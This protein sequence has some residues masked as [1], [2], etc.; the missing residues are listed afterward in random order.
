MMKRLL[1]LLMTV[2]AVGC[3][4]APWQGQNAEYT[5]A[6]GVVNVRSA[7]AGGIARQVKVEAR[8]RYLISFEA[9]GEGRIQMAVFG[10]PATAFTPALKL[11]PEQWEKQELSYF[12]SANQ[13]SLK[14]YSVGSAAGTFSIRNFTVTPQAKPELADR[15]ITRLDF[16]AGDYPGNGKLVKMADASTGYAVWGKRWYRPVSGLPVPANTRPLYYWGRFRKNTDSKVT[17]RLLSGVQTI[18]GADISGKDRWEWVKFPPVNAEAAYPEIS[19]S[20]D[21]DAATQVWMDRIAVSTDPTFQP[22]NIPAGASEN[23]VAAVARTGLVKIGPFTLRGE[24]RFA[25][26]QTELSFRYDDDKLYA[27]FKCYE[28]CLDPVNNRLHEFRDTSRSKD[29]GKIY[30]DDCV[31]LLLQPPGSKDVYEFTVNGG[32]AVLDA[33][34]RG[35][36]LWNGRDLAWNSGITATVGKGDGFWT[37]ELAIPL[38]DIR[39]KIPLPGERWNVMAGRIEKSRGE[40]SSWQPT[41]H[42]FHTASDFGELVFRETAPDAAVREM[43]RFIAGQN[44][45]GVEAN[46]PVEVES[47]V[48]FGSGAPQ[49]FRGEAFNL[50][51]SGRFHYRWTVRDPATLAV[52]YQSPVYEL[53]VLGTALKFDAANR[54]RVNGVAESGRAMLNDGLNTVEVEPSFQGEFEAGEFRFAPP[55]GRFTL[56]ANESTVWP[57]WL[58]D[59]L[60]VNR[61]GLQQLLFQVQGVEGY[62]L[63]DY[64]LY[65]DLPPGFV[66]EG[67]SG[68]YNKWKL[69][70]GEAGLVRIGG[71]EYR[72]YYIRVLDNVIS[73]RKQPLHQYVAVL[74][75]APE[76]GTGKYGIYFHAGSM[77]QKIMEVPQKIDVSLLPPLAGK[78]PQKLLVQMWTGWMHALDDKAFYRKF[79]EHFIAMGVN[80]TLA[81]FEGIRN[82]GLINFEPWN[83]GMGDYLTPHPDAALIDRNGKRSSKYVC[84]SV[85]LDD[86]Q[87]GGWLDTRIAE[88]LAKRNHP[89]HVDWDYEHSVMDSYISC[90]CPRCLKAFGKGEPQSNPEQWTVFM[91]RRM[92]AVAGKLNAAIKK[93]MPGTLFSVYS[94]YQNETTRSHYGVDWSMLSGNIDLAM[95]GYGRPVRDLAATRQVLGATPL[96]LGAIAYPYNVLER[97]APKSI[98]KAVLLRRAADAGQGVLIYYYPTLDGRTFGAIAEVSAIMAQYEP[99][100]LSGERYGDQLRIS[101]WNRTEYELLGDGSG[102][103][104]L[105]LMNSSEAKRGYQFDWEGRRVSGSVEPGGIKVI[106]SNR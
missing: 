86:P 80:E 106:P 39:G 35:T 103:R 32:G 42:G 21:C 48:R 1:L 85:V 94:G 98:S 84:T 6:D 72:R 18:T 56:L 89:G 83:L 61:G 92:A 34:C 30:N 81:P 97:Q 5:E 57:N 75:R 17:V 68:Y 31:I 43:P 9:S 67:A 3:S 52:Y 20:Y 7:N 77:E 105:L 33:R 95:C 55:A 25:R 47:M 70:T 2:A 24:N 53:G 60:L 11:E 13:I 104:L 10:T 100:F 82:V 54:V 29:D 46:A 88:W 74:F 19:F 62:T 102:K 93:A 51:Q 101:G 45:L 16:Q 76:T 90:F 78:Q 23:G 59:G 87:F 66:F 91:N 22:G 36:D 40:V 28:S 69:E 38:N 27:S 37:A 50:G 8:R 99:F 64:T 49:Y 4:G 15:E 41:R 73:D 58:I 63:N 26:E 79:R 65:L 44:R 12:A 71:A 14:I 96:V